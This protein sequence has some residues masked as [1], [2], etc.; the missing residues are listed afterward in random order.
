MREKKGIQKKRRKQEKEEKEEERKQRIR[1]S[2]LKVSDLY[3]E[4]D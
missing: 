2:W 4:G 3:F 1:A